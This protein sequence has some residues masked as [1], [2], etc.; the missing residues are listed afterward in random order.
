MEIDPQLKYDPPRTPNIQRTILRFIY[1]IAAHYIIH[2]NVQK[3][4]NKATSD[5]W[6]KNIASE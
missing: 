4:H 5:E 1:G 3:Q 6:A 2:V